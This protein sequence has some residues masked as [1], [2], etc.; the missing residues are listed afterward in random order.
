MPLHHLIGVHILGILD[1]MFGATLSR[2]MWFL[3]FET[4]TTATTHT[5]LPKP[6]KRMEFMFQHIIVATKNK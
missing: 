2:S 3:T 4:N 6:P 1:C 5:S